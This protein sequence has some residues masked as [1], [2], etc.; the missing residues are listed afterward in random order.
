MKAAVREVETGRWTV[1]NGCLAMT[2]DLDGQGVPVLSRLV[3]TA[4]PDVDRGVGCGL[5][6]VVEIGEATYR[7]DGPDMVFVEAE[8]DEAGAELCLKFR[9]SRGLSVRHYLRLSPDKPVWRSWTMLTND[10]AEDIED[11]RR[12]DAL[13]LRVE[14]SEGE[15]WAAYMLGW[16]DGPRADAPGKHAVPF[17]YPSWIPRLLYGDGAPSPPPPPEGWALPAFRLIRERLTRLPLRSGK[18]STYDNHPWLTVL[19]RERGGGLF[20]GLEWSGTWKMDA[21]HDP[22]AHSVILSASTDGDTHILRA[23]A[24]LTSPSAFVG[25]F[26]GDWDDAFNACRR[27]VRDEILP[28]P[29]DNFPPVHYNIGSAILPRFTPS[30]MRSEIDTAVELG[31]ERFAVDAMWWN[32]SQD[33]G[34][35]SIGLGD[36]TESRRKFPHGLRALSDYVHE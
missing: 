35:F 3:H 30:L 23:G 20:A 15:P 11:I 36:F 24:S 22:S 14:T 28:E 21:D 10:S 12:F 32:A 19:D 16:L 29:L 4:L 26:A 17:P 2:I 31:F 27:Y 34:E 5:G 6:P 9:C 33:Q 25:L 7:P 18:R 1:E 8:V 13:S